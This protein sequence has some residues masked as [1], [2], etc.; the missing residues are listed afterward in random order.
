[1]ATAMLC[2]L[3]SWSRRRCGAGASAAKLPSPILA[4]ALLPS[5][6][7]GRGFG[8]VFG[9]GDLPLGLLIAILTIDGMAHV[10]LLSCIAIALTSIEVDT[11][12]NGFFTLSPLPPTLSSTGATATTTAT[13]ASSPGGRRTVAKTYA[14]KLRLIAIDNCK[15]PQDFANRLT[16]FCIVAFDPHVGGR[17]RPPRGQQQHRQ[18]CRG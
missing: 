12:P 9:G 11:C 10:Q 4:A 15:L 6:G 5:A 16:R 3:T 14:G 17:G 1:M 13:A 2:S 18:Q 8:F 7:G